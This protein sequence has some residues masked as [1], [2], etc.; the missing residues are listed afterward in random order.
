VLDNSSLA[1][2]IAPA[3]LEIFRRALG[4]LLDAPVFADDHADVEQLVAAVNGTLSGGESFGRE[5]AVRA[6]EK[7]TEMNQIMLSGDLV[8]K[9]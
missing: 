4:T 2:E 5:E 8:Y 3:R 7:M 1:T 6:L 9:V